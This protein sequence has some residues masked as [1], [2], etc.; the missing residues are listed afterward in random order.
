[1]KIESRTA[2]LVEIPGVLE[3]LSRKTRSETGQNAFAA[4]SPVG[5]VEQ[6]ARRQT[7]LRSY[8]R[9]RNTRGEFPWDT[10]LRPV[11]LILQNAI[12]TSFLSGEELLRFRV[13]LGLAMRMRRVTR[14]VREEIP[15]IEGL[16]E[17][18]RD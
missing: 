10:A 17:G 4:I 1:M 8:I 3:K 6:A 11:S 12:Q 9:Y 16:A 13:L 2:A 14:D 15:G 5:S 18:I 7:L